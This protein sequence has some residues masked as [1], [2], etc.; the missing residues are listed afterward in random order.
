[1]ARASLLILAG[2]IVSGLGASTAWS[3]PRPDLEQIVGDPY[4]ESTLRIGERNGAPLYARDLLSPTHHIDRIYKSMRGP[5][6]SRKFLLGELG[7]DPQLLWITGFEAVITGPDGESQGSQEFMCHSNLDV[8]PERYHARFPTRVQ[9]AG[10]RLFT[11]AQGQ[12]EVSLPEGFGVPMMSNATLR[13]VNQSLNHN[14]D[15]PD[16]D[17]RQRVKIHYVKDSDL[18]KPIKPLIPRG[19][20][21]MVLVEGEGG[22][23]GMAPDAVNPDL[24]GEGCG[25]AEHM[26]EEHEYSR[27]RFGRK[28]SGFWQVP[29]GRQENH[30]LV[31]SSLDL[32]YDT[33]VHYIAVHLHPFAESLELVD[34]TT[35]E[36]VYKSRTR[37]A[38]GDRIG[39]AEVEH[40]TSEEGIPLYRSHEYELVSI[41]NNTSGEDQDSMAVML[42]YLLAKDLYDFDLRGG[43]L[44]VRPGATPLAVRDEAP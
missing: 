7:R 43:T 10:M 24:H 15:E 22:H 13:M 8:D 40:F 14:I 33:T 6:T 26:G 25:I 21:G 3:E 34:L 20:Q 41:Y 44:G 38:E 23:F 4:E 35:G 11:L 1:V 28:F 18:E 9:I 19:I 16:I 39:L 37:Q 36:T 29:P 12:V 17:L 30:S 32:P 5:K 42:L 27:D 2:A 31:T